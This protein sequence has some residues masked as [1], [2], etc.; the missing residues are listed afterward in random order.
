MAKQAKTSV[1]TA[2]D[3]RKI[4]FTKEDMLAE[5]RELILREAARIYF[6]RGPAAT[7]ALLGFEYEP[8]EMGEPEK[9][10]SPDL[11]DK[12]VLDDYGL[13]RNFNLAY[14]YAFQIGEWMKFDEVTDGEIRAVTMGFGEYGVEGSPNPYHQKGSKCRHV[15]ELAVARY[16]LNAYD[17]YPTIEQLSL[18]A[19]MSEAAVRNSLSLEGIKP[20]GK[21]ARVSNDVAI[22]WLQKRR[23]YIPDKVLAA[24]SETIREKTNRIF[25]VASFANGMRHAATEVKITGDDEA[26]IRAVA[27]ASQTDESFV[28]ALFSG[29]PVADL[30]KLLAVA[31]AL[32][33]DK[34]RFASIAIERALE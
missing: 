1:A 10:Y 22:E 34:A 4:P 19:N 26:T 21:P 16:H 7:Y 3:G 13:A 27:V 25:H 28:R 15:L 30:Q 20:E 31:D 32:K 2:E 29:K 18:L 17:L 11:L 14:D 5:L 33:L 23:G 12:I 8:E 24:R 6:I 9:N